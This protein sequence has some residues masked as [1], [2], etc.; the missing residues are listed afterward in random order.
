M[1][2]CDVDSLLVIAQN[3]STS[4]HLKGRLERMRPVLFF[5]PSSKTTFF[6]PDVHKGTCVQGL[7]RFPSLS[8]FS[9]L[10]PTLHM[11]KYCSEGR[12]KY[13]LIWLKL[14]I[15][16][17]EEILLGGDG[18]KDSCQGDS[19]GP[20]AVWV[21]IHF[22]L[23]TRFPSGVLSDTTHKKWCNTMIW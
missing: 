13:I 12:G 10:H 21:N 11:K 19:G 14:W 2:Y 9:I 8:K 16:V 15:F 18:G 1:L 6:R 5:Y 3:I 22:H 17:F 7:C 20:L 4:T 23:I